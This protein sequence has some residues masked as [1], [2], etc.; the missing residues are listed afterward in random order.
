MSGPLKAEDLLTAWSRG[1]FQRVYLFSGQE[2]FLIEE[3][4]QKQIAR[5]PAG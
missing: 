2:D 4:V 1:Q 3:A 5:V